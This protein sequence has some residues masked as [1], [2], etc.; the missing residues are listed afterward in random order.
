MSL[1]ASLLGA[2]LAGDSLFILSHLYEIFF[3]F[4]REKHTR[5]IDGVHFFVQNLFI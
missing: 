5:E 3:W 4:T 2:Y 1:I